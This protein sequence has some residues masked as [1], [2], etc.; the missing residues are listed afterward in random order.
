MAQK[1]EQVYKPK[2][3]TQALLDGYLY[4]DPRNNP[5]VRGVVEGYITSNS[6]GK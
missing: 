5:A 1:Q 6:K 2:L 4:G 3:D